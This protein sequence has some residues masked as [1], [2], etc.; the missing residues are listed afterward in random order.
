MKQNTRMTSDPTSQV[1]YLSEYQCEN[2]TK[3]PGYLVLSYTHTQY[4]W[5]Q[6]LSSPYYT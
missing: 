1:W 6:E 3:M 5:F 2:A 4:E